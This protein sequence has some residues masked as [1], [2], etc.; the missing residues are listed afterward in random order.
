MAKKTNINGSSTALA[1]L[2]GF[3]LGGRREVDN[4]VPCGY[5]ALDIAISDGLVK[6][7]ANLKEHGLLI[8]LFYM[9][10]KD[11]ARAVSHIG[12]AV[13]HNA[14]DGTAHG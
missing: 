13:R 14:R 4:T 9:E 1:N 12:Y 3:R 10:Q 7:Y 6:E 8:S 11:L 5:T 2:K